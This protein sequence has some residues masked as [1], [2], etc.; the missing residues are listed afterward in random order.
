MGVMAVSAF[1]I[2][3]LFMLLFY[4]LTATTYIV[5]N[6]NYILGLNSLGQMALM[7]SLSFLSAYSGLA[8]AGVALSRNI[9]FYFIGKKNTNSKKHTKQE[10]F[11]LVVIFILAVFVAL[12]TFTSLLGIT[13]ILATVIYSV[14]IFQ[15]NILYYRLLGIPTTTLWVL[16][17]IYTGNIIGI[18]FH[19]I[20]MFF[21]TY[22]YFKLKHEQ[23]KS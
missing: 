20:L 8:M 4:M 11:I 21:I 15:K 10:L 23:S 22:K 2:S 19:S 9:V 1:I 13:P 14:S 16:Y 17:H 5:K 6:R 12:I 18:F 3:Q 7:G